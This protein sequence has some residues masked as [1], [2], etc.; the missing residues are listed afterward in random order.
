MCTSFDRAT[1]ET[2]TDAIMAI[3]A[4]IPTTRAAMTLLGQEIKPLSSYKT[5]SA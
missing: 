2:V 4:V 3:K 5:F 1:A